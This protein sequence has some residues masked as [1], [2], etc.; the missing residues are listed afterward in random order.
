MKFEEITACEYSAAAVLD[1][2]IYKVEELV[3]Y[4]ENVEFIETRKFEERDGKIYTERYWQGTASTVPA[5]LRPFVSKNSLG[6][7]DYGIWTPN[8]W[9][10]DWRVETQHSKFTSCSGINIFEPHP[11]ALETRT[12]CTI[13]G[14][15]TVYGDK[16]P[17]VPAFMGKKM[18]PT[19]EKIILGYM[20]PNFRQLS[21]G[22]AAYLKAKEGA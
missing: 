5:I 18:A 4:M 19:I 20:I 8:E 14:D 16:I 9:R 15:F 11:E 21:V 12:K 1:A 22:M 3:P 7:V 17:A 6:W 2:M 10:V 13:A